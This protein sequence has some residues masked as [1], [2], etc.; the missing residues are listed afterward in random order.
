MP[1]ENTVDAA[2]LSATTDPVGLG[3]FHLLSEDSDFPADST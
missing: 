1:I 3:M 2:E